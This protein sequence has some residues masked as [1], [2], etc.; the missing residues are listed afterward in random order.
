MLKFCIV[1]ILSLYDVFS[2]ASPLQSGVSLFTLSN[3]KFL[4]AFYLVKMDA[5]AFAV[6]DGIFGRGDGRILLDQVVC[7]GNESRLFDCRHRGVGVHSIS[8]TSARDAGIVCPG[9]YDT[10]LTFYMVL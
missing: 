5:G 9:K 2:K 10:V 3:Y 1:A 7:S 8:C 4:I 6:Q